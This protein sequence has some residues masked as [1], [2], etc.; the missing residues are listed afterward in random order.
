MTGAFNPVIHR[1][2]AHDTSVPSTTIPRGTQ[3][4]TLAAQGRMSFQASA[5]Y[6]LWSRTIVLDLYV[7]GTSY[8]AETN[9]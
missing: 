6:V 8:W 2:I 7:R 5:I 4:G 1:A 9:L 3:S